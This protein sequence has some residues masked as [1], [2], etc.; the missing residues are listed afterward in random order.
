M[1]L[2]QNDNLGESSENPTTRTLQHVRFRKE[3]HATDEEEGTGTIIGTEPDNEMKYR[4]E[5]ENTFNESVDWKRNLFDL[6]KGAPGKAF[7]NGLT[8]Q[9]NEW[10]SESP[11]RDICLKALMVMPS[12]IL[13]RT[14]NKCKMSE[15]KSHVERRL[16]HWKNKDV[17]GL[18]DETRTIQKKPSSKTKTKLKYL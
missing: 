1:K 17:E 13:Q 15:I 10:C 9:I 18:L 6:P 12:L 16:N 5:L 11:N 2:E 3:N 7:I 8:K 4:E 14:S